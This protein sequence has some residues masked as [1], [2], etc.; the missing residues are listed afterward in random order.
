MDE[1]RISAE[2]YKSYILSHHVKEYEIR[3]DNDDCISLL[4]DTAVGQVNF[5]PQDIVELQ[6]QSKENEEIIFYLHFQLSDEQH[7]HE[8]FQ[9]MVTTL[10]R[11]KEEKKIKVLLTCSSG[12][13][14]NYFVYL[15]NDAMTSLNMNFEFA[16]EDLAKVYTSGFDYDVILLAPQVHHEYDRFKKIF[17]EQLVLKIPVSVFATYSAGSLIKMIIEEKKKNDLESVHSSETMDL[18]KPFDN[19]YRILSIVMIKYKGQFRF[20]YRIYD[21]GKKTL[22]KEVIK[23]SQTFQDIIDLLDYVLAR[24]ENI[25]AIGLA[26]PGIAYHGY[27]YHPAYGF[28]NH[29]NIGIFL[30]EKYKIPV[31]L[32]NDVNAVALGYYALHEDSENMVFYYQPRGSAKGRAGI[33]INGRLHRGRKSFSGELSYLTDAVVEDAERKKT[34][35]S[36]A[37]EIVRKV[38]IG[39]ITTIAPDKIVICSELTPDMDHLRAL[40]RE[41]LDEQY[42]PELVYA[43]RLKEYM[44]AGAMIHCLEVITHNDPQLYEDKTIPESD[45][46]KFWSLVDKF[47][48]GGEA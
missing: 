20:A 19:P 31:F 9:E 11:Q 2:E 36:G 14:T 39:L 40:L 29:D 13:T 21:H 23:P 18:R 6:I 7:A 34:T 24:H 47:S 41:Y 10:I 30:S 38:L 26:L 1:R 27:L 15:L 4:T 16:A 5:Y 45:V 12:I 33:I 42:I 37:E 8:L 35:P 48:E 43:A 28:T 17:P 25:S 3:Q 22:D 46:K 32:I 44:L